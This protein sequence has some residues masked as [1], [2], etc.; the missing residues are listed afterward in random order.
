VRMP[1]KTKPE[2][3][4][5]SRRKRTAQVGHPVQVPAEGKRQS[6]LS[7]TQGQARVKLLAGGNP[8][9]A[10]AEGDAPVQAYI[11]A[12]PGWK[13]DLG[14]ASTRSSRALSPA[15]AR[16]SSG[17]RPLWRRGPGLVLELSHVHEVR[18]G[19]F[20][21]RLR[22]CVRFPPANPRATTSGTWTSTRPTSSTRRRWRPGSGR[23]PPFPAGA[24]GPLAP[25]DPR[26]RASPTRCTMAWQVQFGAQEMSLG[27]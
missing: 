27:D 3:K 17:T 20:L 10:K 19:R 2:A 11:A 4:V 1:R 24:G 9:I 13:R 8:Q 12:M 26:S 23:Q 15:C 14:N 5:T 16:R 25:G 7:R 21:S 18:Q 22:R 6:H